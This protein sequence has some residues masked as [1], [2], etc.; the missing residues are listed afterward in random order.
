MR[1][2]V[3]SPGRKSEERDVARSSQA[4]RGGC[5]G[6][7]QLASAWGTPCLFHGRSD[8]H[9]SVWA[10]DGRL[11]ATRILRTRRLRIV[12]HA[13]GRQESLCFLAEIT[14]KQPTE[15]VVYFFGGQR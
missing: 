8:V 13:D 7:S 2:T 6:G 9:K 5:V 1:P 4:G 12:S 3:R 11:L 10:L 14:F 15:S